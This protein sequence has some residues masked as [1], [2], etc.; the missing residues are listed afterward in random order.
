MLKNDR[1][2]SSLLPIGHSEKIQR[3][4]LRINEVVNRIVSRARNIKN[5]KCFV[6]PIDANQ[7]SQRLPSVLLK[8]A[9]GTKFVQER[10]VVNS[11]QRLAEAKHA[12]ANVLH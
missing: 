2:E 12:F 7:A 4:T 5:Y 1:G 10:R 6:K 11:R 8:S 3:R 9:L